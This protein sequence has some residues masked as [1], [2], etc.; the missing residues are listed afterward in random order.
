LHFQVFGK[1]FCICDS[2]VRIFSL[3]INT[4]YTSLWSGFADVGFISI[5][6][7]GRT[8]GLFLIIAYKL[9]IQKRLSLFEKSCV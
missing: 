8:I 1:L 3:K 6:S 5:F 4:G 2:I 9:Q 7:Y